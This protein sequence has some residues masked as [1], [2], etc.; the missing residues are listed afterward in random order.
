MW[1]WKGVGTAELETGWGGEGGILDRARKRRYRVHVASVVLTWTFK[2]RE[3]EVFVKLIR[4]VCFLEEV[5]S[6]S[7]EVFNLRSL[8]ERD[9]TNPWTAGVKNGFSGN[10]IG[11]EDFVVTSAFNSGTSGNFM[12]EEDFV[13]TSTGK[14]TEGDTHI[15]PTS[16][17]SF[18]EAPNT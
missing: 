5:S 10:F 2:E 15:T 7:R 17:Y 4:W 8:E 6:S 16:T 13:V 11:E 1:G 9:F 14:L 3:V 18:F 12:G